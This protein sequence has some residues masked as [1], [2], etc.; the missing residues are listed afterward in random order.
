MAQVARYAFSEIRSIV[1]AVKEDVAK[2]IS[3]DE[4]RSQAPQAVASA[5]NEILTKLISYRV[6]RVSDDGTCSRPDDLLPEPFD[7]LKTVHGRALG[8]GSDGDTQRVLRRQWV[9][10][11]AMNRLAELTQADWVGVYRAIPS[12]AVPGERAL[13]KEAYVGAPSRALF[14]LTPAFAENSNNSTVGLS[15]DAILIHDTRKL[16]DDTPYYVCD[17]K[18]RSELCVPIYAPGT[19][20]SSSADNDTDGGDAKP[21]VIGI[22]DA[23]AF[24]PGHFTP[25][26]RDAVLALAAALGEA[27]L[28]VDMLPQ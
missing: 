13:V 7:L 14:P 25:E 17:A 26:R 8:D 1:G 20:V 11:A 28:L 10:Q 5:S 9:L 23:E 24:A 4:L 12:P 3:L 21:V 2:G 27:S 22:I 15:G 18:V 6:P 16:N 19:F